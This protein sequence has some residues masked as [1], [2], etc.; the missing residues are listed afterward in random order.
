MNADRMK[1]TFNCFVLLIIMGGCTPTEVNPCLKTKWY[2][3]KEAE[4]RLAVHMSP[5]NPDLPGGTKGSTSPASF[6]SMVVSGTIEKTECDGQS[7][8]Q[9]SVGNNLIDISAD[10][11]APVIVSDSYWIGH[12]IYVYSFG[13]DKDR[14]KL[15]FMVTITMKDNQSYYCTVYKEFSYQD[16]IR[17]ETEMYYYLLLDIY[18]DGWVKL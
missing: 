3:P 18:S 13:N 9:V 8:G 17:M 4:I 11:P 12:V 5:S 7:T 6:Q 14:I 1:N 16:I 2:L 15:N 10:V